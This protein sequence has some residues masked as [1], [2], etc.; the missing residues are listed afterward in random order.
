MGGSLWANDAA[1]LRRMADAIKRIWLAMNPYTANRQVRAMGFMP[2]GGWAFDCL[3]H[4]L[5]HILSPFF[6][7]DT[8]SSRQLVNANCPNDM[9]EARMYR[10]ITPKTRT[11]LFLYF[12][13]HLWDRFPV[14]TLSREF[15]RCDGYSKV[16][17]VNLI[18]DGGYVQLA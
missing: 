5:R 4:K 13:L 15:D 8:P 1:G 9:V 6:Y 7:L 18:M 2:P 11:P 3:A 17:S 10:C 12:A 14:E 16:G